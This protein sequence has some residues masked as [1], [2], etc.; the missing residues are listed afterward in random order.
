VAWVR[1][2]AWNLA[3]SR[4][5]R[6]R[7]ALRFLDGRRFEPVVDGP[8]PDRVAL[9]EALATLPAAQRRAMV[10][11]YLADLP[12]AEI[13]DREGVAEGT[14]KSWLHR[15]RVALAVHLASPGTTAPAPPTRP[16]EAV[17]VRGG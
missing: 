3:T 10:L 16:A 8:S 17:E 14:V 12:L 11:H 5:R 1:R 2:V 6:A 13:A 4:W 9:M 7:T 15:G